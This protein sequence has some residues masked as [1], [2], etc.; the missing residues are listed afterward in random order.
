[1]K[2]KVKRSFSMLLALCTILGLFAFVPKLETEAAAYT[3]YG[4][5]TEVVING[6]SMGYKT[7]DTWNGTGQCFGFASYCLEKIASS[8]DTYYPTSLSEFQAC[9]VNGAHVRFP[10]DGYMHSLVIVSSDASNVVIADANWSFDSDNKIRMRTYTWSELYT[11]CITYGN[12]S[13]VRVPRGTSPTPTPAP[14][15]TSG[16]SCT[17]AYAGTYVVT[18]SS[19]NLN[20]RSTHS[21]SGSVIGSIPKGTQVSVSMAD[22]NWAHVTYN[23]VSGY[24]SMAYLQQVSSATETP[25]E[26]PTETVS[27]DVHFE[28]CNSTGFSIYAWFSDCTY[29]QI[30]CYCW[31]EDGNEVYSCTIENGG[32]FYIRVAESSVA[33]HYTV[34]LYPDGA[35]WKVHVV[36]GGDN[37]VTIPEKWTRYDE[38]VIYDSAVFNADFYQSLY[39][40]LADM[41]ETELKN[42][43]KKNGLDEGRIASP[44]FDVTYYAEHNQDVVKAYGGDHYEMIN[45]FVNFVVNGTENRSSSETFNVEYYKQNSSD[46]STMSNRKLFNHYIANYAVESRL[47]S[48]NFSVSQYKANYY[49]LEQAY[50]NDWDEYV[51]HYYCFGRDER[52]IANEPLYCELYD[53]YEDISLLNVVYGKTYTDLPIP[54]RTGYV[55]LGWYDESGNLITA[56]T[57]VSQKQV[58][59]L[60]AGWKVADTENPEIT[61]YWVSD[62]SKDGYTVTCTFS[63]NIGVEEV[64]FPTWT[65]TEGQENMTWHVGTISGDTATY[66]VKVSDHNNERGCYYNTKICVYDAGGNEAVCECNDIY[67]PTKNEFT[68]AY[69]ANGGSGA[70]AEQTKPFGVNLQLSTEIPVLAGYD[71][72]GWGLKPN[73][74]EAAYQAGDVFSAEEDITLYA[75][76]KNAAGDVN[77]DGQVTSADAEVISRY[78]A[79]LLGL[80]AEQLLRADVNGDGVVNAGDAV[81]V[82]RFASGLITQFN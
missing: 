31:D 81:L 5:G 62:V 12:I 25:T 26:T 43:W 70:P 78:D 76:W 10:R 37:A 48:S 69:D 18:T 41:S 39:S 79:G 15:P 66:T 63:D 52:R 54:Q 47:T 38:N 53:G 17:T 71:F 1:M 68:V 29:G 40:D 45:H 23:G 20:I 36:N 61:G 24:V 3:S 28:Y 82:L 11:L 80:T 72:C 44:T 56:D 8:Y 2:G 49:D 60:T 19:A 9:A 22:G 6:V 55:F 67:V 50:G 13:W 7:G 65:E 14:T 74:T 64:K 42:H 58:H 59:V 35:D 33:R 30:A 57:T 27:D 16:C 51:K 21:E 46:L 32:Y 73:D 4:N 75:L 34:K 77:R